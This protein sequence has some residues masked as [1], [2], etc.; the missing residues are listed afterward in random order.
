MFGRADAEEMIDD[1]SHQALLG[2]FRG[3]PAVDRV[4]LVEVLLGL[5]QVAAAHPEIA[6]VDLN[7]LIVVEG[8]PIAVD[9]LVEIDVAP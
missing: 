8:K 3:E 4:A 6:S 7:P 1:L 2:E 5:S 9:A